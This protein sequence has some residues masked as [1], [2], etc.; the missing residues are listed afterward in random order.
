M[1]PFYDTEPK[2]SFFSKY[3]PWL[4]EMGYPRLDVN[5]YEDG[6]WEII[7]CLD[8]GYVPSVA[9]YNTVLL[10]I[11]HREPTYY[12]IQSLVRAL[13]ITRQEYW[14][15]ELE[16]SKAVE[17]EALYVERARTQLVSDTMKHIVGNEGLKE[18]IARR[19]VS[20]LDLRDLARHI[21]RSRF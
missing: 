13:D 7:E 19:G 2:S 10:N 21:P 3:H 1:I 6:S 9:K 18:R 5:E 16:K 8:G 4:V 17:D 11:I 15:H 20:A 12:T 14:D